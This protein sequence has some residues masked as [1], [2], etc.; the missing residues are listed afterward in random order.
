MDGYRPPALGRAVEQS[1]GISLQLGQQ[2]IASTKMPFPGCPCSPSSHSFCGVGQ[3]HLGCTF[4]C[5]HCPGQAEALQTLGT[6]L[7]MPA[8]GND[9]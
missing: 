3:G 7:H 4:G 9:P 8:E 1:K 2:D 5:E 6:L